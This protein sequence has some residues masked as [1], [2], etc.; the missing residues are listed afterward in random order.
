ML[1]NGDMFTYEMLECNVDSKFWNFLLSDFIK[2]EIKILNNTWLFNEY[3]FYRY[4]NCAYDFEKTNYDFFFYE[5]KK[6]I[7]YNKD[8]I[9]EICKCSKN[10]TEMYNN[11]PNDQVKIFSIFFFF[12]LW[13]NQFD[14]SWNATKNKNEDNQN[15]EKDIKK[16][17]LKQKM[18]FFDTK[19]IDHL[20]N[21]FYL[22]NILANDINRVYKDM[23]SK[24]CFIKK[25]IIK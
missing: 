15:N 25:K 13:S 9:E 10:L 2:R 23:V 18:F 14:L 20:Y 11:N 22:E 19:N 16:K 3:Y 24:V 21:S 7:I 4:L 8:L 12:S 17:S 1:I 5:K 6:S